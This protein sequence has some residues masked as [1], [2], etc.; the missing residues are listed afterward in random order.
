[1]LTMLYR[2]M[3]GWGLMGIHLN[4]IQVVLAEGSKYQQIPD[5]GR[6]MVLAPSTPGPKQEFTGHQQA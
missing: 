1:M 5:S 3:Q 6:K 4:C 2:N